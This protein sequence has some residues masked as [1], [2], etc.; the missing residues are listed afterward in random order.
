[1]IV[2][3]VMFAAVLLDGTAAIATDD[4]FLLSRSTNQTSVG[5][6]PRKSSNAS[7]PSQKDAPQALVYLSSGGTD[8]NNHTTTQTDRLSFS[9]SQHQQ[10]FPSPSPSS[11]QGST[12]Y[13][14]AALPPS[15]VLS[16]SPTQRHAV[17]NDAAI[18]TIARIGSTLSSPSPSS[19]PSTSSYDTSAAVN[20]KPTTA[21]S[22]IDEREF[23]LYVTFSLPNVASAMNA[24]TASIF[25][26]V[27]RAYIDENFP[28]VP[29]VVVEVIFV[30]VISQLVIQ[31][32][33]A[34]DS[35]ELEVDAALQGSIA[36]DSSITSRSRISI[37]YRIVMT[38][39]TDIEAV[40][41]ELSQASSF[42]A[43][44][45]AT[46][47]STLDRGILPAGESST[48]ARGLGV[49]EWMVVVGAAAGAVMICLLAALGICVAHRRNRIKRLKATNSPEARNAGN[50]TANEVNEEMRSSS[51]RQSR[52]ESSSYSSSCISSGSDYFKTV[53]FAKEPSSTLQ[54]PVQ[55]RRDVNGINDTWSDQA[56][57]VSSMSDLLY[58]NWSVFSGVQSRSI[59]KD[60]DNSDGFT[61]R[62]KYKSNHV[63]DPLSMSHNESVLEM[64]TVESLDE[65]ES[66][67]PVPS[68]L[69]VGDVESQR[70]E[71]SIDSVGGRCYGHF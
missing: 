69:L 10:E 19:F 7:S 29:G 9:Q 12:T 50:A 17:S 3:T 47:T 16:S 23:T 44:T 36:I 6:A 40:L 27:M 65:F 20:I 14:N 25:E 35:V 60:C 1:M 46:Y 22:T 54:Y 37:Q 13:E 8:Q 31:G 55:E 15:A 49:T 45:Q 43:P 26:G 33:H 30:T 18:T 57:S 5:L 67:L 68:K 64:L 58:D 2:F 63:V 38:P 56:S 24:S 70:S 39:S 59:A 41:S 62:T 71:T 48:T 61:G 51:V 28:S 34:D 4:V 52:G 42:F 11:F 53:G 32:D 66:A 21:T